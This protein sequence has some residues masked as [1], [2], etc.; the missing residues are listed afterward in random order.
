MEDCHQPVPP[1]YNLPEAQESALERFIGV[2][3]YPTYKL[4]LPNG[5]LLPTV[6]PRS[7]RPG[8]VRMMIYE[9]KNN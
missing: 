4:V 2:G 7:D 5:R 3:G 1:D 9:T 6:A 8:A